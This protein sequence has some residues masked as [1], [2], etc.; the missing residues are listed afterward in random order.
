[1]TEYWYRYEDRLVSAG[2]DEFERPLGPARTEVRLSKLIVTKHTPRGVW[3]DG[4]RFVKLNSHK[5]FACPTIDEA[6]ESFIAR[7]RRQLRILY[8]QTR[9]AETALKLVQDTSA[10]IPSVESLFLQINQ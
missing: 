7:K 5:R 1:M 10:K 6:K 8:A 3:L 9:R 4:W 2:V